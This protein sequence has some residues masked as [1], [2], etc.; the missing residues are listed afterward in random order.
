M[1]ETKSAQSNSSQMRAPITIPKLLSTAI[2]VPVLLVADAASAQSAASPSPV[3]QPPAY[4]SGSTLNSVEFMQMIHTIITH[5]DL[6]DI[7]FI[8]KTLKTTFIAS[9]TL[10]GDGTPNNFYNTDEIDGSPIHVRVDVWS[11]A[12]PQMGK[13]DVVVYNANFPSTKTNFIGDRLQILPSDFYSS[14]ALPFIPEPAPPP[15]GGLDPPDWR[16][17][18]QVSSTEQKHA[19][20]TVRFI[21]FQTQSSPGKNGT[22]LTT[23]IGFS[24][25]LGYRDT[26]YPVHI[27]DYPLTNL[28]IS[29]HS[30]SI[31]KT[32]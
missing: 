31:Q 8:G 4:C 15:V 3:R 29:Q 17:K 16:P 27:E 20:Y 12:V 9:H 13:A 11:N 26:N 14:L 25:K 28:V 23:Q 1:H 19:D 21:G 30:S 7:S 32:N 22:N 5:G 2:I 6:T 24:A 18:S 10:N